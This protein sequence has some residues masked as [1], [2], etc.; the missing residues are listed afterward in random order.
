M[1][2][3]A[4][5]V[6]AALAVIVLRRNSEPTPRAQPS[7]PIKQATAHAADHPVT[8][9]P[10][11]ITPSTSA[12]HKESATTATNEVL[13]TVPRSALNTIHG[14]IRVS[15]Q[16]VLNQEGAVTSATSQ[17]AGPSRYFERL[18]LQSAKK[19]TF[20]PSQAH[21]RRTMYVKFEF[22]RAGVS[23]RAEP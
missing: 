13:P 21:E 17:I 2:V 16:V 6:I 14:T 9:A 1:G 19:W 12:T 5:V 23:A 11:A 20:T 15:I 22:T 3:I 4:L 8:P 10:T 18:S 7:I